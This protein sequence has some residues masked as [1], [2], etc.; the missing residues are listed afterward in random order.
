MLQIILTPVFFIILVFIYKRTYDEAAFFSGLGAAICAIWFI[1]SI[2][3]IPILKK[4][5]RVTIQQLASFQKVLQ[6]NRAVEISQFERVSIINQ[7]NEWNNWIISSQEW[8]DNPWSG[9]YYDPS[10]RDLKRIE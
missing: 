4:N 1:L 6:T 7:I 8:M 3:L 2:A 10:L 5:D 9:I